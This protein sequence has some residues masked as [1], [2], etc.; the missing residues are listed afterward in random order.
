M[1]LEVS[2]VDVWIASLKD[3][4]GSLAGK[5]A[6]LCE[7]GANLDFVFARRSP[8][9]PGTGVV[10]LAPIKGARQAAAARKAG[11]KKTKRL[12][13]LCVT[14]PNRLGVGSAITGA[15][16][17]AGITLKGFSAHVIGRKFALHIALDSSAAATKAARIIR[18]L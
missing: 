10:F 2:R 4:P 12:P 13:T 17:E 15:M 7:A 9:K 18:K 1:K 14:G 6:A 16:A 3:S 11:L 5:L 8:E